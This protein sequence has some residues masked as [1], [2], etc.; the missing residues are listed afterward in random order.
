[1][2]TFNELFKDTTLVLIIGLLDLLAIIQSALEDPNW[3]GYSIEG[4]VFAGVVF[5]IFCFGMSRYSQALER[6]L[7]TGHKR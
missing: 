2:N 4:Y 3:L 5:W 7:H 1:V 6:K